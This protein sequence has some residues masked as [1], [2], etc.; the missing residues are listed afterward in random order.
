MFGQNAYV[1]ANHPNQEHIKSWQKK[2]QIYVLGIVQANTKVVIFLAN[3]NTVQIACKT[4]SLIGRQCL[5]LAKYCDTKD[6][7]C[8]TSEN[9]MTN[10]KGVV[11]TPNM[12]SA[13]SKYCVQQEGS[14]QTLQNIVTNRK[15]GK[16]LPSVGKGWLEL[17]KYCHHQGRIGQN[18]QNIVTNRKEVARTQKIL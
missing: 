17:A 6:S 16:I 11:R 5:D 18:L 15:G 2:N 3:K 7:S 10:T 14:G 4:L 12:C 8:Q 13:L 9:I 1:W